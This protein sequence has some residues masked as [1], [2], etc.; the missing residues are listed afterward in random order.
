MVVSLCAL[1]LTGCAGLILLEPS[2]TPHRPSPGADG[3]GD[4]YFPSL[5]NG[6]YDVLHYVLDLNVDIEKR[7]VDGTATIEGVATQPLSR[8]TLD[9]AGNAIRSITVNGSAVEIEAVGDQ[10]HISPSA[11]IE[12][13]EDFTVVVDYSP[14]TEVPAEDG[15]PVFARGWQFFEGG[16]YVASE[17]DGASR[18]FPANDH[19]SDKA[20]LTLRVTV[21][22]PYEVAASGHLVEVLDEGDGRT[23]VWET[24]DPVAP[25]LIQ[26]AIGRFDE[27]LEEGD[28]KTMIRNYFPEGFS[29]D[30][31]KQYA[32]TREMLTYFESLF[33]PYPF[34]AYGVVVVDSPLP[35]ALETQTL[36]LF[37][38]HESRGEGVVA[39][40]LAHSWFGNSVSLERWEDIWLNEGFATYA[41]TLW[42]EDAESA[43]SAENEL[44]GMYRTLMSAGDGRTLILGDPG[45]D[46]LFDRTVYLR[47][48]LTLHALR[49]EVG[50][51]KFFDILRVY[52]ERYRY[53]NASTDD[54]IAVAEEISGRDLEQLFHDWVFEATMPGLAGW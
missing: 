21:G 48:A 53:G 16:S 32:R 13:G 11:P 46:S 42:L 51:E 2:A 49:L 27:Q 20:L 5:G 8:L 54:F 9:F 12:L 23:Y 44:R 38:A 30:R 47:G 22:K 29:E 39:H 24:R 14:A 41:M 52:A 31:M 28:G 18:W 34:E 1:L 45:P 15:V 6:G 10:V 4:R 50:S 17:P 7:T 37:G 26:V 36:T 35:Y 40:E 33:G 25:Y 43:E 19:P 3:I